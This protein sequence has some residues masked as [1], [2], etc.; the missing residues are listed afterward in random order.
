MIIELCYLIGEIMCID[1]FPFYRENQE[2]WLLYDCE[3]KQFYKYIIDNKFDIK[4]SIYLILTPFVLLF[5]NIL[6]NVYDKLKTD[7]SNIFAMFL[8]ALISFII[9]YLL[10]KI[11]Y[12]AELNKYNKSDL[13]VFEKS[14]LDNYMMLGKQQFYSILLPLIICSIIISIF[15]SI[16]YMVINSGLL[17][18]LS[19]IMW[20][21]FFLLF[22]VYLD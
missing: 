18:C 19:F 20:F 21:I 2:Y 1:K 17:F 22:L 16:F 8:S 12:K 4:K 9:S 6:S 15:M 10:Y 7:S 3:T 13:I 5:F 14:E 11:S